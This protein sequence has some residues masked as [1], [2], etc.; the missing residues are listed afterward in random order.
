M[1]GWW[2]REGINN[3]DQS[4]SRGRSTSWTGVGVAVSSLFLGGKKDSRSAVDWSGSLRRCDWLWADFPIGFFVSFSS[5]SSG[6]IIG[7]N[8]FLS[9]EIDRESIWICNLSFVSINKKLCIVVKILLILFIL[10][11]CLFLWIY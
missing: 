5:V 7:N 3:R 10:V 8:F 4:G 2:V 11:E 9:C 1:E 6:E